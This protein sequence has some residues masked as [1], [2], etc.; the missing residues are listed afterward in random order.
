MIQSVCSS[1]IL[2]QSR[3]KIAPLSRHDY[4]TPVTHP[5]S[6]P[7]DKM[8]E[9]ILADL[10]QQ[11]TVLT[12]NNWLADSVP[13]LTACTPTFLV[14]LVRNA[15]AQEW[16]TG[17]LQSVV[18]RSLHAVG[19]ERLVVC[20]IPRTIRS[21]VRPVTAVSDHPHSVLFPLY[22]QPCR[23]LHLLHAAG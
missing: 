21:A 22:P 11:M 7:P 8:W 16:L 6:L 20:F 1:R 12:Y 15:Y 10:R 13:L 3:W 4:P 23:S 14:V 2:G 19:D 5:L 18:S 9:T 17:S